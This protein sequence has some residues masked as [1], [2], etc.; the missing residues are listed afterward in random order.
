MRE[1]TIRLMIPVV[2]LS[3]GIFYYYIVPDNNIW[4][5]KCPWWLITGTYCP[6]C[7]IQRFLHL[8][9]TGQILEAFCMNPFLLISFPYVMLAVIGKWYN[10]NGVFDNL[11]K[12]LYCRMV[13]LTYTILF[14]CWWA[15]RIMFK[16]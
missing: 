16:I 15:I 11:N 14:F 9:L 13:L 1:K 3:I 12:F 5:P 8:F 2:V 10:I 6:S 4:I 7:G